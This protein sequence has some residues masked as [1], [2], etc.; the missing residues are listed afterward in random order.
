MT[1]I[2]WLS[3]AKQAL[4]PLKHISWVEFYYPYYLTLPLYRNRYL[5]RSLAPEHA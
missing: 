4:W 3:A 2:V 5:C 1:F